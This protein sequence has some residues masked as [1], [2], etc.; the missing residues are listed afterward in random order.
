MVNV[1]SIPNF[2]LHRYTRG[3]YEHED[4]DTLAEEERPA[5]PE[6]S[7]CEITR[8]PLDLPLHKPSCID[9]EYTDQTTSPKVL[10]YIFLP[11]RLLIITIGP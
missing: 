1:L 8:S 7:N 6:E 11:A 2:H 3:R 5:C 9:N 4:A 10:S